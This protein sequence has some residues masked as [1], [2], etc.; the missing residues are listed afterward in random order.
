MKSYATHDVRAACDFIAKEE[1][2]VLTAYRCPAGV[3]TIGY[4]HTGADVREGMSITQAEA[5]ELL[6]R[7]VSECVRGLARFVNV[8]VTEGQFIA[9][10]SLAFNVGVSYVTRHCPK[11]MRALNA[12]DAEACAHEFLDIDRANGVKLPGLTRR[13]QSEARLFLGEA[14]P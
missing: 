11:L 9:L 10:T 14:A 1:G 5:G 8:P 12:G 7:D 3:L 2:C 4:G 13:R 6:S